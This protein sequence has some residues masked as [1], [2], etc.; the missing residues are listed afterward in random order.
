MMERIRRIGG[1]VEGS[2]RVPSEVIQ[3]CSRATN[4]STLVT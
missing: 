4:H 3:S 2:E 1:E